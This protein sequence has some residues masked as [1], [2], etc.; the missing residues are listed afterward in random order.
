MN[1]HG[2]ILGFA[3]L[4]A[5]Q[6]CADSVTAVERLAPLPQAISNN[7]VSI[8][9]D[10]EEYRLVSALGLGSGKSWEDTSSQSFL[11]QSATQNW[12]NLDAIP[13]P[14]GRLAASA[15]TVA[16]KVYLFGGYTVA[17]DGSEQSTPEVFQL[18][19]STGQ[20][21]KFAQMP[22]PTED[23]VLLAYQDRYIYLVS[24]WHDLGNVN[25]VQV[26]DTQTATWQQAT[27][28]PGAPVFGHAGALSERSMVICDGVQ[29]RYAAE[30]TARQ[31]L[32]SDECWLGEISEENVRRISWQP[33][34]AH[35][36]QARYRMA[37]GND[38]SNRIWFAGGS[39]NPY[40]FDGIGYDGKPAE[41]LAALF[42]FNTKSQTWSCHGKLEVA[43][44][45]HRGLPWHGGWFYLIG[46]MRA[47]QTVS[48]EVIR[49]RPPM[50]QPCP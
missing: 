31:F 30:G 5:G 48:A 23:A 26:L 7:A 13:G 39:H 24:G 4:F 32:S 38:D 42:S 9:P 25:L 15:I 46:G 43:T 35:P 29:I 44:M 41:P 20:W 27:P 36:G 37:S 8:L 2:T 11:Y 50:E 47:E 6:L 10:E 17:K 14:D 12:S 45:D 3:L 34:P 28:Y 49:F 40:N 21:L 33:L 16:G 22:V 18:N 19:E 1:K